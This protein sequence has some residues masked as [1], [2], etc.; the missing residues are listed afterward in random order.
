MFVFNY[1]FCKIVRI[2][3]TKKYIDHICLKNKVEI[4]FNTTHIFINKSKFYNYNNN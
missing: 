4:K 1:N 3:Y 2:E